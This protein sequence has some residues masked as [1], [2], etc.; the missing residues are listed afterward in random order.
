MIFQDKLKVEDLLLIQKFVRTMKGSKCKT[1]YG[2]IFERAA[3]IGPRQTQRHI[4]KALFFLSF[5]LGLFSNKHG[6]S[7]K[8]GTL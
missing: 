8:M 4:P 1:V 2:Q 5:M 7:R 3:N 6:F